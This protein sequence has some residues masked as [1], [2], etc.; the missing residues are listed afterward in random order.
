MKRLIIG[1]SALL[2]LCAISVSCSSVPPQ[3]T[4][5]QVST[6]LL[7]DSDLWLYGSDAEINPFIAPNTMIKG[8]PNEFVVLRLDVVLSQPT[9]LSI[10]ADVKSVDGVLQARLYSL[11]DMQSYWSDWGDQSA[12]SSRERLSTLERYYLPNLDFV[13]PAGRRYYLVMLVGKYPIKRPASVSASV[14][15]GSSQPQYF[16]ATLSALQK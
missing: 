12:Y 13:A 14:I 6:H 9:E 11:G 10:A 15:V 16:E 2:A 3:G 5:P 7:K 8:R 1:F 4:A